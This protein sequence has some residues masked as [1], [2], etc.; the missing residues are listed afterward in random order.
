MAD[1]SKA[2]DAA[3]TIVNGL[4]NSSPTTSRKNA[5]TGRHGAPVIQL[6]S[7]SPT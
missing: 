2:L 7:R 1:T 5:S 3:L 4:S 6:P